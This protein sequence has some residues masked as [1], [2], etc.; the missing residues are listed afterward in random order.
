MGP[1][2]WVPE[3]NAPLKEEEVRAGGE[4]GAPWLVI[5]GFKN[6]G[7]MGGSQPGR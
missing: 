4:S 5:G 3:A 6:Y 2:D 7:P 1:V